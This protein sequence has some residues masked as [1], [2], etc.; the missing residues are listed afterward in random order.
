MFQAHTEDRHRL[1]AAPQSVQVAAGRR[2]TVPPRRGRPPN[3]SKSAFTPWGW[4]GPCKKIQDT[5]LYKCG[6]GDD[7]VNNPCTWQAS[8][9]KWSGPTTLKNGPW[10]ETLRKKNTKMKTDPWETLNKH[11]RTQ[12]QEDAFV[13]NRQ[14]ALLQLPLYDTIFFIFNF[15]A[16]YNC[17]IQYVQISNRLPT[18]WRV[19]SCVCNI[20]FSF[21]TLSPIV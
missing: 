19:Q 20:L 18:V 5:N 2:R 17:K 7:H 11:G 8:K 13:Q 16:M 6:G 4:S 1:H 9:T 12:R 21:Y 3:A 10:G 15:C 14:S